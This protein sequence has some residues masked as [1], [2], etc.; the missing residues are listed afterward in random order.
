MIQS[1]IHAY[2]IKQN[3]PAKCTFHKSDPRLVEF[4]CSD[5]NEPRLMLETVP[6]GHPHQSSTGLYWSSSEAASAVSL[7]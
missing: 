3:L 2:R 1:L 7:S 5:S 4:H 6:K